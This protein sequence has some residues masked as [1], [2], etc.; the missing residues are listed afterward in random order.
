[1]W[2]PFI[3]FWIIFIAY[4]RSETFDLSITLQLILQVF[5][6]SFY[7]TMPIR[8][9]RIFLIDLN[10]LCL[11]NQ[12]YHFCIVETNTHMFQL[13]KQIQIKFLRW[14]GSHFFSK[15]NLFG[16][17]ILILFN[18]WLAFVAI[19]NF[20]KHDLTSWNSFTFFVALYTHISILILACFRYPCFMYVNVSFKKYFIL[21][22]SLS[23]FSPF[24]L[25]S[26]TLLTLYAF[27]FFLK[28]QASRP[29]SPLNQFYP[30]S[31]S[32]I[33]L[34]L[35]LSLSLIPLLFF[36]NNLSSLNSLSF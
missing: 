2:Y 3:L 13:M 6:L 12:N 14:I 18:F 24:F 7:P 25:S 30:H 16:F 1:M 15:D 20:S 22:M 4:K 21:M 34:Q 31:L 29:E 27:Y 10:V 26:F 23:S 9:L 19:R 28:N 36:Y 17:L 32:H 5:E 11:L 35:S 33:A 8:H